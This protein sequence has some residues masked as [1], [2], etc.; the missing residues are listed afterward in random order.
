MTEK[1]ILK[2]NKLI[3]QFMCDWSKEDNNWVFTSPITEQGIIWYKEVIKNSENNLKYHSSWNYI[4]PAYYKWDNFYSLDN[5]I[6]GHYSGYEYLC[7]ELDNAV[8]RYDIED[9]FKQL[10][11]NIEWYNI[12]K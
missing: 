12:V 3:A 8:T 11:I 4:M 10:V 1:E 7:D 9:I 2:G 6:F 5:K